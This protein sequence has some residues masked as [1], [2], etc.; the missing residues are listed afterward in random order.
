MNK[1]IADRKMFDNL[2]ELNAVFFFLIYGKLHAAPPP[3][4][5]SLCRPPPPPPPPPPPG[6][7]RSSR[8]RSPGR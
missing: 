1:L 6:T 2:G 7:G 4:R 5:F 8:P 3:H